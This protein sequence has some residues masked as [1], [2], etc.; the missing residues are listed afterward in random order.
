[1]ID[2]EIIRNFLMTL[3]KKE[4]NIGD[5]DS[6]LVTKILDSLAIAELVVFLE[7]RFKVTLESDDLI[8][9]NLDSIN[10]IVRFLERKKVF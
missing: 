5:D 1:M 6:L 9:E 2:K 4:N 3:A 7:A 10:A 8:P